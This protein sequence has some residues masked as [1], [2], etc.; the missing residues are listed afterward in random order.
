MIGGVELSFG[1][2]EDSVSDRG[3]IISL[4]E[5]EVSKVLPTEEG[6]VFELLFTSVFILFYVYSF[7]NFGKRNVK[8]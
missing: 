4:F 8:R 5:G 2:N 3:E 7:T 6:D 1:L